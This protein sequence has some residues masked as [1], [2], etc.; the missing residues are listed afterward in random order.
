LGGI[1]VAHEVARALD[2]RAIFAEREPGTGILTLRRGFSIRPGE[3]AL[4]LEDVV[5]TGKSLRETMEVVRAHG[6]QVVAAGALVD[7]SSSDF[8]LDVPFDAIARLDFPTYQ[9]AAC[10]LCQSGS[11][12]VKPG[13]RPK[14]T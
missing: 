5:T 9:P 14:P 3:K 8:S 10:P 4:V 11:R 6:G 1:L 2:I 13:S 12:P 7:R